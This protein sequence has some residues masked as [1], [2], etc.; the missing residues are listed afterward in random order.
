MS[1]LALN[2]LEPVAVEIGQPLTDLLNN[3]ISLGCHWDCLLEPLVEL[4]VVGVQFLSFRCF[5]AGGLEFSAADLVRPF[6]VVLR[7]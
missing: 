5:L 2:A 4:L 7:R 6:S 3:L 1:V